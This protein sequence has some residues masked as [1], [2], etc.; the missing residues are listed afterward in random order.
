MSRP[1]NHLQLVTT[2]GHS[3][4]IRWPLIELISL[5]QPFDRTAVSWLTWKQSEREK[6]RKR[7]REAVITE[8]EIAQMFL[9][10][11]FAPPSLFIIHFILLSTCV[12]ISPVVAL[13]R[14]SK[15]LFTYSAWIARRS[16]E[17]E[18]INI[19]SVDHMLRYWLI[20]SPDPCGQFPMITICLCSWLQSV[21]IRGEFPFLLFLLLL[22]LSL[23]SPIFPL[24]C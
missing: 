1:L 6:E 12:F 20:Y 7:E 16:I 19:P 18:R 10:A 22:S 8:W 17:R 5:Y 11:H 4:A 15:R 23:S 2:P 21:Y 3:G 13:R 24:R 9:M 14:H